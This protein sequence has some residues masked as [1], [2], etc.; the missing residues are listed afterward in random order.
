MYLHTDKTHLFVGHFKLLFKVISKPF[1]YIE[2]NTLD[3]VFICKEPLGM[4][5]Y[6]IGFELV[7]SAP[8][9]NVVI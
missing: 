9:Y 8:T 7:L 2:R 4:P 3:I 6:L 5:A 1:I